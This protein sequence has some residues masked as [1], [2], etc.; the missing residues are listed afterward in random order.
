[1]AN[2]K[3]AELEARIAELESAKGTED[4]DEDQ[5][6]VRTKAKV[7]ILYLINS[8]PFV[9]A[10]LDLIE[11]RMTDNPRLTAKEAI[12]EIK[13]EF[14]DK[15]QQEVS[16]SE[17]EKPLKQLNPKG[18]TVRKDI[19]KDALSGKVENADPAQLEAYKAMMARLK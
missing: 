7:E 8:D 11:D 4:D 3:N 14:F 13:S 15:M 6:D 16:N 5:G 17:P 10:N 12:T 9:K 18:N 1:L 19:I 2:T